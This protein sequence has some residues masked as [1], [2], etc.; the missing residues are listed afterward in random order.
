MRT[1]LV[2]GAGASLANALHF[3][4]EKMRHLRPPLDT[5]F[6]ETVDANPA[7]SL[8][9]NLK[10]YFNDVLGR[11]PTTT[12]LREY[13]MEEV[14]GDVYYDF[15]EDQAGTLALSAYIG[16]VGLYLQVLRETTNWLREKGR[17]GG[18]VGRLITAAC[19]KADAV[20]IV[21]FNHDL[22]IE[23]ELDRRA[24]LPGLLVRRAR[25]RVRIG[26]D[27]SSE[28]QSQQRGDCGGRRR[29]HR[30]RVAA[31]ATNGPTGTATGAPTCVSTRRL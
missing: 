28:P 21:T 11:E 26:R 2:F 20:S 6:F 30:A 4:S 31:A 7:T 14:F 19:E 13:R 15:L 24:R 16:L 22:V 25:L 5:T 8:G 12:T 9:P 10:K 29:P 3:R 17:N 23:N 1:C 18:P 27:R